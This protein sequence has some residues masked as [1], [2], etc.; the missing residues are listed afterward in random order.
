MYAFI[1][2]TVSIYGLDWVIVAQISQILSKFL[3]VQVHRIENH[4]FL[5]RYV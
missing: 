1:K 4:N 5:E 3:K 2:Y